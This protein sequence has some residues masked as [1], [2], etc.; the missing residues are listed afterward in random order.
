MEIKG[1]DLR[2]LSPWRSKA[3]TFDLQIFSHI[4]LQYCMEKAYRIL[5]RFLG[6]GIFLDRMLGDFRRILEVIV[7][8][9]LGAFC[10]VF[11]TVLEVFGEV[12]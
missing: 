6:F 10:I 1:K 8:G 2:C 11:N 4:F 5:T 9:L 3:P 12:F 7:G